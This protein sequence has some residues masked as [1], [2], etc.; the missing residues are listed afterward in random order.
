MG[1]RLGLCD[2]IGVARVRGHYFGEEVLVEE[3]QLLVDQVVV[4]LEAVAARARDDVDVQVVDGLARACSL[5]NAHS[6]RVGLECLLDDTRQDL[7]RQTD[8]KQL[9]GLQVLEAGHRHAGAEEHVA[10]EDLVV[11]DHGEGVLLV[12]EHVFAVYVH[13][14]KFVGAAELRECGGGSLRS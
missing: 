3:G 8:F 2:Q 12:E 1:V 10:G 11:D 4:L 14:A 9:L 13:A 7:D 5:L 6:G